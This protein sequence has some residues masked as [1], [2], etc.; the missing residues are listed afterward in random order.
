MKWGDDHGQLDEFHVLYGHKCLV[1]FHDDEVAVEGDHVSEVP[2]Q[3]AQDGKKALEA[4]E[5]K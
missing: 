5:V 4:L 1:Q 2:G 3:E